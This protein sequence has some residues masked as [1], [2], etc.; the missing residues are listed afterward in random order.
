MELAREAIPRFERDGVRLVVVSI[1]VLDRARDFARENDFPIESVHADETSATYDLIANVAHDGTPENGSYRAHAL[2]AP[3][4][5]WYEIQDLIVQEVLPQQVTL[6]E[7]FIQI[8]E[9]RREEAR[10]RAP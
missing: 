9:R 1:G 7:T 4:N 3:D 2:H 8:Y 6:A 5:A 10:A